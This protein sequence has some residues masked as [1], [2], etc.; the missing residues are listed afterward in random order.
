MYVIK[1]GLLCPDGLKRGLQVQFPDQQWKDT[2]TDNQTGLVPS[3]VATSL[4]PEYRGLHGLAGGG[5]FQ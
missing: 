5:G 1:L 3:D 4:L 2:D